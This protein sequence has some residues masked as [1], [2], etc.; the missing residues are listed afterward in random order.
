MSLAKGAVCSVHHEMKTS[1]IS[2]KLVLFVMKVSFVMKVN[3]VV[4]L[5]V[6]QVW[7]L[8]IVYVGFLRN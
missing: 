2:L 1:L 6:F 5:D 3:S 8:Q 7:R 4:N